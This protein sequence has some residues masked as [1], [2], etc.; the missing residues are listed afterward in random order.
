MVNKKSQ[1]K[2]NENVFTEE[3]LSFSIGLDEM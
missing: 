3:I 2:T 1:K